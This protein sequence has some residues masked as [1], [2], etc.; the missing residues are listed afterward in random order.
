MTEW[1]NPRGGVWSDAG[2][3]SQG[4]PSAA[5]I[6][7][8]PEFGRDG[9][10]VLLNGA[11]LAESCVV[12]GTGV[13]LTGG[14]LQVAGLLRVGD[15][16][17][18]SLRVLAATLA[19]SDVRIGTDGTNGAITLAN[20]A[21]LFGVQFSLADSTMADSN[22]DE[23]TGSCSIAAGSGALFVTATLRE[24]GNLVLE[25]AAEGLAALS[26]TQL[27]LGGDLSITLAPGYAPPAPPISLLQ[28]S[29]P[30]TGS[31]TTVTT[32]SVDGVQL[33]ISASSFQISLAAFDPFVSFEIES[34][35]LPAY[36]GF[37]HPLV[38]RGTRLSGSVGTL[39]A[40]TDFEIIDGDSSVL[41]DGDDFIPLG[42]GSFSVRGSISI[43]GQFLEATTAI[44]ASSELPIP[45]RRIDRA[46]DGT[47]ANFEMSAGSSLGETAPDMTP[48]GRFVAFASFATNLGE[49]DFDPTKA[50]IFVKDL[51]S[52]AV[53]QL[54]DELP[55]APLATQSSFGASISDDGRF[56]VFARAVEGPPS[57]TM[58]WIHDRTTGE[59]TPLCV[60]GA[61]QPIAGAANEPW[62][63]ADG[64]TVVYTAAKCGLVEG[65]VMTVPQIV[66]HDRLTGVT[67]L[68]SRAPDGS[69]AN[70]ACSAPSV[71]CDG[72]FVAYRTFAT[73]LIDGPSGGA[74]SI[75]LH[76]RLLHTNERMDRSADA[77]ANAS[78]FDPSISCD[79][80]F[81]AF[82]SLASNLGEPNPDTRR[83][84]FLRDRLTNTLVFAS[85][86]VPG[87][88]GQVDFVR[89]SVSDDGAFIS[90]NLIEW[91][92][93]RPILVNVDAMV[94]QDLAL[95]PWGAWPGGDVGTIAGIS[96]T[97]IRGDGSLV[98]FL[99]TLPGLLPNEPPGEPYAPYALGLVLRD[100]A[101]RLAADLD[102]SGAVDAADLAI[103][104]SVWGS[105]ESTADLDGD[106]SVGA[107]DI[108]ILLGAWS[109]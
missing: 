84:L 6:A 87:V 2:N 71:S 82:S 83:D 106:G 64:M 55:L 24:R 17:G 39:T 85:P 70:G 46:A 12:E 28:S 16:D 25:A 33:A 76:D 36:V 94:S 42:E 14:S 11:H 72:R 96:R 108:A 104:L 107:G 7:I 92:A 60:D 31:F 3:W 100:L 103:L 34:G 88:G 52:G 98:M 44:A 18:A 8:F 13:T 63:S 73:N 77:P 37:D 10:V 30:V 19:G 99:A 45:Y 91:G 69:P 89:P 75:V 62:I 29:V 22:G 81:V 101:N 40:A 80:R 5:D 68:V 35:V 105:L 66:A 79:G 48:D 41:L 97:W 15:A 9:Y 65:V 74:G 1:T 26:A 21:T 38:A 59:S 47:P 90:C 58:I 56:V 20:G 95:S 51:W 27:A 32:P 86:D 4:V 61:G 53:D 93:M 109:S 54:D 50:N 43:E 102:R 23:G 49:T 57:T 78:S 67:T